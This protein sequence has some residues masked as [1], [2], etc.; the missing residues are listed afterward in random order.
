MHVWGCG[1]EVFLPVADAGKGGD[2][3]KGLG[4]GKEEGVVV[5]T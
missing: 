1:I 2:Q 5:G 4:V 3:T